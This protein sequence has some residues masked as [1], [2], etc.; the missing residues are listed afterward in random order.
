[1]GT[2]IESKMNA[3]RCSTNPI[4]DKKKAFRRK[5]FEAVRVFA[6]TLND[7]DTTF[8][9]KTQ[10]LFAKSPSRRN[11][12]RFY[13]TGLTLLLFSETGSVS[14]LGYETGRTPTRTIQ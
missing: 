9:N 14:P 3:G 10:N 5:P 1:M 4:F 12:I 2:R 11:L 6:L 7:K 13:G 8:L